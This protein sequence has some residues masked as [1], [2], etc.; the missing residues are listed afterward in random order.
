V[1]LV[2]AQLLPPN[3]IVYRQP[4]L[5]ALIAYGAFGVL[6][7]LSR[8]IPPV[9]ILFVA[10]GIL[11]PLGWA[12]VTHNWSALGFSQRNRSAALGWGGAAGML[13]AAYTLIFFRHDAALPPL[14]GL[15]VAIALPIWLLV[16]SPF[17]EFFFRGWLQPRL[18]QILG[19]WPGLL[20]T[21]LAFMLW[22]FFPQLEGT[23]TSTL[24]LS[25]TFGLVSIFAGGLLFG[26]IFQRTENIL[27]PWLAHALGG[28]AL[29]LIGE[30]SFITYR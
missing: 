20:G 22:H 25:S 15:Q 4:L 13:W 23:P 26:Y 16:L 19:K 10:Y 29:V 27:A 18:Q 30:M 24:P 14:W 2:T 12:K 5:E 3:W 21:A 7:I 8:F 28:I 17:Q 1:T 11:F 6:G 9:F